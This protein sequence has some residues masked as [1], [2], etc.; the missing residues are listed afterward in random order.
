MLYR[1]HSIQYVKPTI[2]VLHYS[3]KSTLQKHPAQRCT[4]HKS[5]QHLF[6]TSVW[7]PFWKQCYCCCYIIHELLWQHHNKGRC[8]KGSQR[9]NFVFLKPSETPV[10]SVVWSIQPLYSYLRLVRVVSNENQEM[11]ED[12][13]AP[14]S[15]QKEIQV[16]TN[17][18]KNIQEL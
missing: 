4:L 13:P 3:W 7:S 9:G 6:N 17:S 8:T 10:L 15:C 2:Q 12:K 18:S 11:L 14:N 16:F 5:H 1:R